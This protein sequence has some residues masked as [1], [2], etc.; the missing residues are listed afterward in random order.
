MQNEENALVRS[1]HEATI[2]KCTDNS[3]RAIRESPLQI[4]QSINI[5]LSRKYKKAP[6]FDDA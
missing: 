3:M 5:S 2:P 4:Y 1:L 6:S